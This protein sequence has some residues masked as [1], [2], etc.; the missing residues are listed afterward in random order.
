MYTWDMK[1]I[2][3]TDDAYERLKSWKDSDL[4]SF[5]KVV[6][7]KVPKKGTL[8]DL[9]AHLD[10]LPKLTPEEARTIEEALAQGNDWKSQRDPWTT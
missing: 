3:L 1:T 7:A 10:G 9:A 6:L 5:S 8:A 4:D 2:T